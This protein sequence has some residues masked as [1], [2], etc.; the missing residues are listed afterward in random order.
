MGHR[1][2]APDVDPIPLHDLLDRS[3]RDDA[4]RDRALQGGEARRVERRDGAPERAREA[5]AGVEDVADD[6]HGMARNAFEELCWAP[7][8]ELEHRAELIAGIDG[9]RHAPEFAHGLEHAQEAPQALVQTTPPRLLFEG[10][11]TRRP[12]IKTGP[13]ACNRPHRRL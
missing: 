12:R 3:A 10:N 11:P 5:R 9:A 6:R 1:Q 7:I 13:R 4:G 8:P 2:K